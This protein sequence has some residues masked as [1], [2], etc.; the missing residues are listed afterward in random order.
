MIIEQ[1]LHKENTVGT[2]KVKSVKDAI[3][4]YWYDNNRC[5]PLVPLW[6]IVY[7]VQVFPFLL[8]ILNGHTKMAY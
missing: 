8:S 4:R 2:S 5:T 1:I 6:T 7:C 3:M